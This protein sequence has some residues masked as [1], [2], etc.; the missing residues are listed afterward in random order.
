MTG[1]NRCF[2]SNATNG[3][4]GMTTSSTV[5]MFSWRQLSAGNAVGNVYPTG[6]ISPDC[7]PTTDSVVD[8]VKI[9]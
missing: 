4:G 8:K 1:W 6:S 5:G 2:V 9:I 7:F 3:G